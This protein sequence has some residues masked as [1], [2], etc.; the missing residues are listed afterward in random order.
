[1]IHHSMARQ[2]QTNFTRRSYMFRVRRYVSRRSSCSPSIHPVLTDCSPSAHS[3]LG[4]LKI[5]TSSAEALA[6]TP[7]RR[8][9][10]FESH[11]LERVQN[12]HQCSLISYT[13]LDPVNQ[14]SEIHLA[15]VHRYRARIHPRSTSSSLLSH[16]LTL[17]HSHRR[18]ARP[19]H[20]REA[21]TQ[22]IRLS[23]PP[24]IST[25]MV[26]QYVRVFMHLTVCL[27][28]ASTQSP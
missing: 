13:R 24:G 11:Q 12:K 4:T 22:T 5:L 19:R 6:S 28:H 14:V 10:R 16:P 7:T 25:Q 2:T 3:V 27:K 18:N 8:P 26:S 1:M 17:R 20:R 15:S 23:L 21:K 9:P